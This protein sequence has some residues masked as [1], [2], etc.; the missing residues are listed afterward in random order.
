MN[1]T[2]LRQALYTVGTTVSGSSGFFYEE[3]PSTVTYPYT[4][5]HLI[6]S[7]HERL[8]VG[9]ISESIF[10]QMNIFDR[11]VST[12]GNKIS[13]ATIEAVA[14]E[15][16]LRFDK[17]SINVTN[18]GTIN[19]KRTLTTPSTIVDDGTYWMIVIRYQFQI[20][21]SA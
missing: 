4:V 3:A 2:N 16:M 15:L 19:F 6:D 13:S 5:Y 8:S 21:Q 18:Y 7:L 14:N 12:N 20:S 11:R 17:A 10:I 9:S 1:L